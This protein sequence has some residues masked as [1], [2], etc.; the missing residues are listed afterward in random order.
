LDDA[1]VAAGQPAAHSRYNAIAVGPA[2]RE[3]D[4]SDSPELQSRS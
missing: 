2:A 3:S 4:M 1:G